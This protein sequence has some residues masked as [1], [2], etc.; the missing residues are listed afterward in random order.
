MISLTFRVKCHSFYTSNGHLDI[1]HD[2][3]IMI[4]H[5]LTDVCNSWQV[6]EAKFWF[7]LIYMDGSSVPTLLLQIVHLRPPAHLKMKIVIQCFHSSCTNNET[8]AWDRILF[9]LV[10]QRC[11]ASQRRTEIHS[12]KAQR[13]MHDHKMPC[14]LWIL[15]SVRTLSIILTLN[16]KRWT[17][18]NTFKLVGE[19]LLIRESKL[20]SWRDSFP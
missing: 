16:P 17:W 18:A 13:V 9:T 2:L 19:H 20:T 6:L 11:R 1:D 4:F 3:E 5:K 15:R 8:L 14:Q 7:G 12:P 10:V